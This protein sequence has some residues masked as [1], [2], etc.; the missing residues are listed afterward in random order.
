MLSG[1]DLKLRAHT[2]IRHSADAKG[3][4][5]SSSFRLLGMLAA[6]TDIPVARLQFRSAHAD[7]G[8]GDR[9]RIALDGDRDAVIACFDTGHLKPLASVFIKRNDDVPCRKWSWRNQLLCALNGFS[10]AR[11]FRQWQGVKRSVKKGEKAFFILTPLTKKITNKETGEERVIVFGFGS[12]AVFGAEQT[13]G[14]PLPDSDPRIENWIDSLP[15][16][17]L[18][19]GGWGLQVGVFDGEGTGR[20]MR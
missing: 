12:A 19:R 2:E 4:D 15:F 8:V 7:P 20:Q 13:E 11:G 5:H 14:E 9:H 10:D 17:D 6:L 16:I 18:V 3:A 1:C